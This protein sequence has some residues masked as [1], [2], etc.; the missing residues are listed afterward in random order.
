MFHRGDTEGAEKGIPA[1]IIPEG[2]KPFYPVGISRP[3]KKSTLLRA[4]SVSAVKNRFLT[5]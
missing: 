2:A 5:M 3:D 1:E 4:L